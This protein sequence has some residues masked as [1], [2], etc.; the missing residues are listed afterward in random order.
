MKLFNFLST[1][2]V[3]ILSVL[4]MA[5]AAVLGADGS[6][7]MA[8]EP[9]VELAPDPNP[10][11]EAAGGIEARID[12]SGNPTSEQ[13]KEDLAGLKTQMFGKSS[14]ATDVRDAGLEAE[15]FDP[16]VVL[17]NKHKY[18]SETVLATR[19]KPIKASSMIVKHFRVGQPDLDAVYTGANVTIA[20]G[21]VEKSLPCSDF[22]NPEALVPYATVVVNDVEGYKVD[23]GG[24][25]V[26]DGAL[27]LSVLSNDETNVKFRVSNGS[28]K[29]GAITIPQNTKFTVCAPAAS[30]SQMHVAPVTFLPEMREVYLQKKIATCI[31]TDEFAEQSKKTPLSKSDV[32]KYTTDIF[33]RQCAR[34][35]WLGSEDRYD[36]KVA[37]LHGNRE[38][39]YKEQGIFRQIPSFYTHANDEI[40]QDDLMAISAMMFT[41]F[42][43][44][45][46]ATFFC[47]KAAMKRLMKLFNTSVTIMKDAGKVELDKYGIKVRKWVDNFGTQEYIYDPT[48]DELGYS[49]YMVGLDL[50]SMVRYYKRDDKVQT[51]DMKKTGEAREA[52]EWNI[53]RTDCYCIKGGN[54]IIVCPVKC[55]TKAS[56]LGGITAHFQKTTGSESGVND[57]NKGTKYY[58]TADLGGFEAGTVIE[59]NAEIEDWQQFEGRVMI[60]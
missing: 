42:A 23:A 24:Q 26:S 16:N 11:D 32:I 8:V 41:E 37:E 22:K 27:S 39:A 6:F 45:D 4:L 5:A 47:G 34:S 21:A 12:G 31:I 43:Q 57:L 44:S 38:A 58:L 29:S 17:F 10:S 33:K 60:G 15:D 2:K 36:V 3:S 52:E 35:H 53:S 49:E 25:E 55:A 48:L 56:K 59:F 18:A 1:H 46:T 50:S 20:Q 9:A 7:A 19:V 30:E 40:T 51:R 13:P 28:T 54:A 14:T